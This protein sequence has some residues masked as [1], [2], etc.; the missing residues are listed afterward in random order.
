VFKI[1][2]LFSP[3]RVLSLKLALALALALARARALR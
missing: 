3:M 2:A 1:I